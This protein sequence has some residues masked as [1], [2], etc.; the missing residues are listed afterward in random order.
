MS[1]AE[2]VVM[3]RRMRE[4]SS[5]FYGLAVQAGCHPFIEFTGLMN[6]YIKCCEAAHKAGIDFASC[7]SGLSAGLGPAPWADDVSAWL[8]ASN[9]EEIANDIDQYALAEVR[10][11]VAAERERWWR[12]FEAAQAVTTGCEDKIDSFAVPSHLIAALALALD[13]RP[14]EELTK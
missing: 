8:E 5:V 2:R 10:R 7:G 3:L 12:L 1:A 9:V 11:A 4:A 6:E 13:D 14:N